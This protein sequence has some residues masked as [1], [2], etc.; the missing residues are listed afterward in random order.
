MTTAS[1]CQLQVMLLLIVQR[2]SLRLSEDCKSLGHRFLLK[3]STAV[4][5]E[6]YEGFRLLTA[7][8]YMQGLLASGELT[9]GACV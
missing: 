6:F 9:S 5:L 3:H 8:D 1:A 2:S 4:I 7:G